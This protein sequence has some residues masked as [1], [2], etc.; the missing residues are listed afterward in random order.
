MTNIKCKILKNIILEQKFTNQKLQKNVLYI[1]GD[2]LIMIIEWLRIPKRPNYLRNSLAKFK[3][4][5]IPKNDKS[6]PLQM[7]GST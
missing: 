1:Y 7:D 3:I 5:N 2:F 4:D 6:Y